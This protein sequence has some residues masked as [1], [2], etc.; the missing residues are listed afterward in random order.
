MTTW[1]SLKQN[2][3]G[4]NYNSWKRG[5]V[6]EEFLLSAIVDHV[7]FL[8]M[9]VEGSHQKFFF[10]N[11]INYWTTRDGFSP[12]MGTDRILIIF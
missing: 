11:R 4:S 10:N 5:L 2:Q 12:P 1:V 7:L 3:A 9:R 6:Q 8:T